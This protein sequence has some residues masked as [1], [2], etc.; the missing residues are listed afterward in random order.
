MNTERNNELMNKTNEIFEK[1]AQRVSEILKDT[2]WNVECID[3]TYKGA[4]ISIS[5]DGERNTMLVLIWKAQTKRKEE[6]FTTSIR[7]TGSFEIFSGTS[8]G[9]EAN[10]Y[11]EAGCLLS[12]IEALIKIKE[13]AKDF[14]NELNALEKEYPELQNED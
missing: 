1:C 4:N 14:V 8:L 3:S 9:T 7:T 12:N 5:L 13:A 6:S 10:F 11:M 2:N